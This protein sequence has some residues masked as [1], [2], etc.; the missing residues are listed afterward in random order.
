MEGYGE[1]HDSNLD[2]IYIGFFED[3]LYNGF[4]I[5]RNFKEN[6]IYI[7]EWKNNQRDGS[8]RIFKNKKESFGKFKNNTKI[9]SIENRNDILRYINDSN[10]HLKDFFS[11]KNY[12]EIIKFTSKQRIM[13]V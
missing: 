7:G 12:N 11:L 3:N 8:A 4:G 6:Y 13:N 10:M 2:I 5:M 9:L 1:F